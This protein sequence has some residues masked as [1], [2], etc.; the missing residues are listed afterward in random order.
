MN[1]SPRLLTLCAALSVAA[2]FH[3]S[4]EAAYAGPRDPSDRCRSAFES[5][6]G[7]KKKKKGTD[8]DMAPLHMALFGDSIIWGQGL[9]ERD[10]FWCRVQQWVELKTGRDVRVWSYAHSGAV[11]EQP[12]L[13]EG[14][15]D[16]RYFRGDEKDVSPGG[17]NKNAKP[18][19]NDWMPGGEV[20]VGFPT[21]NEQVE[22]AAGKTGMGGARYGINLVLVDGCINDVNFRNILDRTNTPENV[23]EVTT[24]KCGEPMRRLL[25]NIRGKFPNAY[26]IV[27]G[28]YPFIFKGVK[29]EGETVVKGTA[30]NQLTRLAFRTLGSSCECKKEECKKY[31]AD[32]RE[33]L[34]D[35]S[36][37]WFETSNRALADAVEKT[38]RDLPAGGGTRVHFAELHFPPDYAFSTKQSLLWNIRFGATGVGGLRKAIVVMSDIFRAIDTNDD[39]WD[40]R[41]DQCKAASLMFNQRA[42]E[43]ADGDKKKQLKELLNGYVFVC[44]RA[45][46]GHPNRFG[47]L[48]YAQAITSR[49]Q[50][51]LPETGWGEGMAG[52]ADGGG[53]PQP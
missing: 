21:I 37:V 24:G 7:A 18:G 11:I 53:P 10:K 15:V 5:N 12:E 4:G 2:L 29:E 14:E 26:V 23:R 20:N 47:A 43:V 19:G 9:K 22:Q 31:E 36:R 38:N 44:R 28:Y 3:F 35:L 32:A 25:T 8:E 16:D 50:M 48:L 33:K 52:A 39:R 49:L 46:L 45:S 30:N 42:N 6:P 34:D 17:D 41:G 1:L 40:D 51:I 13:G 27:T